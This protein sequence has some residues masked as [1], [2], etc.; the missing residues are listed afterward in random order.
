[1]VFQATAE[2]PRGQQTHGGETVEEAGG[3]E[4]QRASVGSG[5]VASEQRRLRGRGWNLE[6]LE[7]AGGVVHPSK[8]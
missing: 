6:Q 1:M 3:R 2:W 7:E 5:E 8:S 4:L